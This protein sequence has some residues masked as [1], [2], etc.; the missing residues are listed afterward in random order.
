MQ[1]KAKSKKEIIDKLRMILDNPY[2]DDDSIKNKELKQLQKKLI[3]PSSLNIISPKKKDIDSSQDE[4]TLEPSVIIHR[5]KEIPTF[6]EEKEDKQEVVFDEVEE[7][8]FAD[9]ELY[10]IEKI[11]ENLEEFTEIKDEV[12]KIEEFPE[13]VSDEKIQEDESIDDLPEWETVESKDQD[14]ETKVIEKESEKAIPEWEPITNEQ[15]KDK[16]L[17]IKEKFK[18][19]DEGKS[20]ISFDEIN[21]FSEIQSIDNNI[22]DLLKNNGYLSIDD[23]KNVTIKDL[24]SAY[25]YYIKAY[26]IA[27]LNRQSSQIAAASEGISEIWGQKGNIDSSLYYFKIYHN[28]SDSLTDQ[29]N[30]RK[31]AMLDAQLKYEQ[32]LNV[33]EQKRIREEDKERTNYLI[34]SFVISGL[35]LVIIVMVLLLKLLRTKAKRAAMEHEALKSELEI[36]NKE[37]TT[38]VMYQLK[39]NEFILSISKKLQAGLY[40]LKPENRGLI[41]EIIRNLE[42]DSDESTWDEFEVR[43]HRVH[44]DFN[45]KLLKQFPDLSANELRLCAFLKLNMNTKEI[46]AITYQSTNSIDTARSRLR[47]K[48]GLGKD[49]NLIGFL[50]QY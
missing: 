26:K 24:T 27:S 5:K 21:E 43:F 8:L 23:L 47:Q 13:V 15:F 40:K 6:I 49:D 22:A 48:L 1:D 29:E 36:R 2:M 31:L 41:E 50:N 33:E 17:K 25:K 34:L 38:H 45:K 28:Y 42:Q 7:D 16:I 19:E 4:N 20:E 11:D 10:E 14:F 44:S 18:K 32:K 35:V 46:A 39:K 3:K 9:E 30:I 12:E 37:L